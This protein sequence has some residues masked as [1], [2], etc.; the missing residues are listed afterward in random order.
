MKRVLVLLF[1]SGCAPSLDGATRDAARELGAQVDADRVW[2]DVL[3]L[4][5]LHE[6]DVKFDCMQLTRPPEHWC[7]LSNSAARMFVADRFRALGLE[8]T[9]DPNETIPPTTNVFAEIRGTTRPDEVI[10]IGAHF[11][12]FFQ[13]ADDNSSSVAVMLEVARVI[14][15]SPRERTVRVVGYDLEELG[16]LGSTRMTRSTTIAK[17]TLVLDC[18]G[19]SDS[20]P[21]SQL[22]LPGFPLPDVGDFLAVI[23]N[24]NSRDSVETALQV[25]RGA[26]D[27]PKVLS[28]VAAGNGSGPLVGNLAR[29]DHA[30]LWLAGH[31]AVFLTDTANFRNPNYHL[32]T[33]TPDTLDPVFLGGVA[34]VATMTISAWSDAK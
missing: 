27:I 8:P 1:L 7:D 17:A 26:P 23:G 28:V 3:A 10:S 5:Q 6:N 11:D 32:D 21:G 14:A 24:D 19:Y 13:G 18:V 34:R 4:T 20:S 9:F 2:A 31:D 29:S 30:P 33:D 16:L 22:G 12:A 15:A 25:S